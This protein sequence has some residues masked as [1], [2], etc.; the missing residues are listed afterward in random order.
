MRRFCFMAAAAAVIALAG[1]SKPPAGDQFTKTDV[2]TITKTIQ[3]LNAAFNAKNAEKVSTFFAG[4]GVLMPPNQSTARARDAVKQYYV[5]RFNE[6]ATDLQLEP[7]DIYGSGSLGYASG[8]YRLMV[9]TAEP[10]RDRGKFV[11]IFRKADN[12]WMIEYVIFSSDF[13]P[14]PAA[15]PATPAE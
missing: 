10:Q 7:K 6:G 9:G 8:D 5:A 4:N 15:A 14:R 1:C 13:A 12:R 11:W 3:D 2:E